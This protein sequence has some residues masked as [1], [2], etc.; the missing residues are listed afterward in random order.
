MPLF[1]GILSQKYI[2][3]IILVIQGYFQ[4][5]KVISKVENEMAFDISR[6]NTIFRQM[7][8]GTSVIPH[9]FSDFNW[10]IRFLY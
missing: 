2:Y 8:P 1:H 4:G 10:A 7:K 5:R 6:S 9:F 3:V